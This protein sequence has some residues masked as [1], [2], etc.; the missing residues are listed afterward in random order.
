MVRIRILYIFCHIRDRKQQRDIKMQKHEKVET[1]YLFLY[2]IAEEAGNHHDPT[3]A[4][5][6]RGVGIFR[7]GW[8]VAAIRRFV[9]ERDQGVLRRIGRSRL[10]RLPTAAATVHPF[11]KNG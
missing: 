1:F 3:P 2:Q 8:L 10:L 4:A 9:G 11:L 6:R 5:V 7:L